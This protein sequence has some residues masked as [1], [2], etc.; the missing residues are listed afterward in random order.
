MGRTA[1]PTPPPSHHPD[2]QSPE[3]S[4]AWGAP[5]TPPD[6]PSDPAEEA[7]VCMYT[8]NCDTGSQLRKAISHIF[9]RN[10]MCTRSIPP[11]VWVH[12][13]RK[14]YQRSRYRNQGEYAKMQC[15]L[16]KEQIE[17]LQNWSESNANKGEG[18]IVKDWSLA[19]RKR[20]QKR[21]DDLVET[22]EKRDGD[23]DGQEAREDDARQRS[24]PVPVTA[25]PSWLLAACG[26]GYDT[27]RICQILDRLQGDME[28]DVLPVFPDIEILPNIVADREE[29]KSPKGYA[30]RKPSTSIHKRSQS[31]STTIRSES[32]PPRRMSQPV[33]WNPSAMYGT[34]S[35]QQKRKRPFEELNEDYVY[36]QS[37]QTQRLR[38]N[39]RIPDVGARRSSHAMHRPVFP[40]IQ[41]NGPEEQ[42]YTMRHTPDANYGRP[43]HVL[44]GV[45][46]D[47]HIH[48]PL[49]APTPQRR[50]S[51]SMVA[52]LDSGLTSSSQYN[53]HPHPRR[54]VHHRS[55]SDMGA[56][57]SQYAVSRQAEISHYNMPPHMRSQ[58]HEAPRHYVPH[59][60][61]VPQRGPIGHNRHLSTPIVAGFVSPRAH[62]SPAPGYGPHYMRQNS[63]P[64][65]GPGRPVEEGVQARIIYGVRH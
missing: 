24:G 58:H 28:S 33:N 35:P 46:V 21:L 3:P 6:A 22:N 43:A 41:E 2:R 39:E 1:E 29:P 16:I 60:Y 9:G 18:G 15:K 53:P 42:A 65:V 63:M 37:P 59:G 36:E 14:H 7:I 64:A 57:R 23:V 4:M 20:E 34:A 49:P 45:S 48:A 52:H 40:Q 61:S 13:C 55:Q 19:I 44:R 5:A 26:R 62:G 8:E 25:V 32:M 30:K 31:L 47:R 27:A 12:F 17:R 11:S 10:K 51:Q 50:S 54:I 38:I 56:M